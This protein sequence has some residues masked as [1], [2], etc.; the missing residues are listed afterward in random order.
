MA[1]LLEGGSGEGT[2]TADE[3]DELVE[4]SS[5]PLGRG[6]QTHKPAAPFVPFVPLLPILFAAYRTRYPWFHKGIAHKH[7]HAVA[8]V[9]FSVSRWEFPRA[10]YPLQIMNSHDARF[11]PNVGGQLHG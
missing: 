3:V 10:T 4:Y 1:S 9:P 6:H 8:F 5:P 7:T 11:T 2:E